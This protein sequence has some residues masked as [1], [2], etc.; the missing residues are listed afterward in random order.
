MRTITFTDTIAAS[1]LKNL[2]ERWALNACHAATPAPGDARVWDHPYSGNSA[3]ARKWYAII[4]SRRVALAKAIAAFGV[5]LPEIE[6][7]RFLSE[8][9][10]GESKHVKSGDLQCSWRKR[11]DYIRELASAIVKGAGL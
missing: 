5:E 3:G 8:R 10:I 6:V 1:I 7:A 9:P 2:A 11:G 4:N